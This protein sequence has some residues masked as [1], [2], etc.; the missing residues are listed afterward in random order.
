MKPC[1]CVRPLDVFHAVVLQCRDAQFLRAFLWQIHCG[2]RFSALMIDLTVLRGIIQYLFPYIFLYLFLLCHPDTGVF[3]IRCVLKISFHPF[4]KTH[5]CSS[6]KCFYFLIFL[7]IDMSGIKLI[8]IQCLPIIKL[9][10][11]L[12]LLNYLILF[13]ISGE[14]GSVAEVACGCV[15]KT[16]TEAESVREKRKAGAELKKRPRIC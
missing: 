15:L 1:G 16:A 7:N 13:F 8:R 2:A 6:L 12:H 14:L 9:F 3:N 10:M 11:E 4:L 5:S